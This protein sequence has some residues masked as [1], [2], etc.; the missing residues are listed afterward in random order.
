MKK[1]I[2]AKNVIFTFYSRDYNGNDKSVKAHIPNAIIYLE[3][4]GKVTVNRE[5]LNFVKC[6][7][8]EFDKLELLWNEE[9]E[10]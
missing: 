2:E 1:L 6:E 8:K 7:I 5:P 3:T 9:E 10:H 4:D